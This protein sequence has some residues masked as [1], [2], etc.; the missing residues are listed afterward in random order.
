MLFRSPFNRKP[1]PWDNIDQDMYEFYV[2]MGKFRMEHRQLFTDSCNFQ[3]LYGDEQK[4]IYRRGEMRFTVDR[5]SM[6][7]SADHNISGTAFK[8]SVV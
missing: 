2:T 5:A 6:E 4:V 7:I 1:F 3:I 8:L